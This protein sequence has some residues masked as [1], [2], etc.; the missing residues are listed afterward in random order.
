MRG[1]EH[2]LA[3]NVMFGFIPSC[4]SLWHEIEHDTILSVVAKSFVVSM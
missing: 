4:M 3:M 2:Q 1:R